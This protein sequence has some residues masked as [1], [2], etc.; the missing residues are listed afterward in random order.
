[1]IV[2]AGPASEGKAVKTPKLAERM[3][4]RKDDGR[5]ST[6]ESKLTWEERTLAKNGNLAP[7]AFLPLQNERT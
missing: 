6:L 4:P 5:R 7:V 3:L 2:I 1:M